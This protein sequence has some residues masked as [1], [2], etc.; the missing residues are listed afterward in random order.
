MFT[1]YGE[2]F[3]ARVKTRG[4]GFKTFSVK[5]KKASPFLLKRNNKLTLTLI[6]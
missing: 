5:I 1:P 6:Y 3:P 2:K 4:S